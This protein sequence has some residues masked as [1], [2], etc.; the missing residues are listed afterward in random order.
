[1]AWKEGVVV[2]FCN[3]LVHSFVFYENPQ[4]T[5]TLGFMSTFFVL[6]NVTIATTYLLFPFLGWLGDAY[7]TRYWIVIGGVFFVVMTTTVGLVLTGYDYFKPE[8]RDGHFFWLIIAPIYFLVTLGVGI[9]QSNILQFT[10]DQAQGETLKCTQYLVRWYFWGLYFSQQIIYY[11]VIILIIFRVFPNQENDHVIYDRIESGAIFISCIVLVVF[12][13]VV[14][15]VL[16]CYSRKFNLISAGGHNSL[17][18][19]TKVFTYACKQRLLLRSQIEESLFLDVGKPRHGGPFTVNEVEKVKVFLQIFCIILTLIAFHLSGDTYS[20][21]ER[22]INTKHECPSLAALLTVGINPNHIPYLIPLMAIPLCQISLTFRKQPKLIMLKKILLGLVCVL[23]AVTVEIIIA[24]AF[25][26][27]ENDTVVL[28]NSSNNSISR[29][30]HQCLLVRLNQSS[31]HFVNNINNTDHVNNVFWWL[32][33]PQVLK[34]IGYLLVAMVTLEF[35]CIQAPR[36]SQGI[37]IGTWYATYS[38]SHVVSIVGVVKAIILDGRLWY[39]YKGV[40]AVLMIF[41]IVCFSSI[42]YNYQYRERD[43][44][45]EDTPLPSHVTCHVSRVTRVG[46]KGTRGI[47]GYGTI[48]SN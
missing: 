25:T 34:G 2:V 20:L 30:V 11:V 8:H 42:V 13:V 36:E 1:M 5:N 18:I 14:L 41:L 24:A 4:L 9:I 17:I 48:I 23:L 38:I 3:L 47:R 12:S 6:F 7:L 26:P 21:G 37:L 32:I 19:F 31:T 43:E 22:I 29:L 10:I 44:F 28:Q 40:L 35:I 46:R 15:F 27:Y 16:C 45:P 39:I 33:T